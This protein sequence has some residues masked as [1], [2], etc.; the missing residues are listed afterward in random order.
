MTMSQNVALSKQTQIRLPTIKY[1]KIHKQSHE[2]IAA[3]C[4][5]TRRTIDRDVAAWVR[6]ED[7][8]QWLGELWLHY[9]TKID[10]DELVFK[11]LSKIVARKIPQRFES[12]D[13]LKIVEEKRTVEI[14]ALLADYDSVFE[15]MAQR[16]L[17]KNNT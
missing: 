7:F 16:D 4:K 2:Q 5:V 12:K 1:G 15:R 8:Y 13:E 11:E 9:E 6:T 3:A 17:Q 10:N 14:K